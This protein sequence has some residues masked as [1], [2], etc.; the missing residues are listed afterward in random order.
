MKLLTYLEAAKELRI[1]KRSVQKLVASKALPV[2]RP[3]PQT[4]LIPLA[5]IERYVERRTRRATA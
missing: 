3:T 4:P 1:S 5:G 2:C